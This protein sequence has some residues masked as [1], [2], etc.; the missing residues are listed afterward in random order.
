MG[1]G[2]Q[3]RQ[4]VNDFL[5][6]KGKGKAPQGRKVLTPGILAKQ[7]Y[8]IGPVTFSKALLG[9]IACLFCDVAG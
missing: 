3:A 7:T 1:G 8:P 5:Q 9:P 2:A 6:S 4:L